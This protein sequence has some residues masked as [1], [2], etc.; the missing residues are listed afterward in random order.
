MQDSL[1]RESGRKGKEKM[2]L[3]GF[4]AAP[5]VCPSSDADEWWIVKSKLKQKNWLAKR[6][7]SLVFKQGEIV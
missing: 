6:E 1:Q 2:C 3:I 4:A 5:A 7:N